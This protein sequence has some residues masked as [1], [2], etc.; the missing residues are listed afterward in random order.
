[1]LRDLNV[2]DKAF[3]AIVAW[4]DH[5][6][7]PNPRPSL[8]NL[9]S[10]PRA[11]SVE[12]LSPIR[13]SIS[14]SPVKVRF[15]DI[16]DTY[17]DSCRHPNRQSSQKAGNRS[18]LREI[19]RSRSIGIPQGLPDAYDDEDNAEEKRMEKRIADNS[20][21][22]H[23]LTQSSYRSLFGRRSGIR[24]SGEEANNILS[25][26][27]YDDI[28]SQIRSGRLDES[29]DQFAEESKA[30][31]ERENLRRIQLKSAAGSHIQDNSRTRC[32]CLESSCNSKA[33][34][35]SKRRMSTAQT[36]VKRL[37]KDS[38]GVPENSPQNQHPSCNLRF[39]SDNAQNFGGAGGCTQHTDPSETSIDANMN[40]TG[41]YDSFEGNLKGLVN[42]ESTE[43][44]GFERSLRTAATGSL[45]TVQPS[46]LHTAH[47]AAR[48]ILIKKRQYRFKTRK[49]GQKKTTGH[50]RARW[51]MLVQETI[52]E[53]PFHHPRV[54]CNAGCFSVVDPEYAVVHYRRFLQMD[55]E[56]RKRALKSMYVR[57]DGAFWFGGA[58]VCTRFLS[59]WLHF[60]NQLQCAVKG[61]PKARASPSIVAVPRRNMNETK[62]NQIILYLRDL[63]ERI[64]DSLPN[65][66]HN[67]LPFMSKKQVF[68][69][70]EMFNRNMEG[71]ETPSLSYWCDV[72]KKFC[73]DIKTHRRHGFT[74]F[75]ICEKIRVGF[76]T[77]E[78]EFC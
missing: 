21:S 32:N 3:K 25:E 5:K 22:R 41:R 57:N 40:E 26:E 45:L 24:E 47:G 36:N 37:R 68:E 76:E 44:L 42:A 9:G 56:D 70:F 78:N 43:S 29:I 50:R 4:D 8:A 6:S 61:T 65:K 58:Y 11:L 74:V 13:Q 19:G 77:A 27:S 63:S 75:D 49:S 39:H 23:E 1:M 62:K 69:R 16:L 34:I 31:E 18:E 46:M 52:H 64:G 66:P 55:R 35:R 33:C 53:N 10:V 59:R 54:C 38:G 2:L 71:R 15:A 48:D 72:W 51:M 60:S 14:N 7:V 12:V 73:S 67:N 17:N 30:E 28:V 20:L